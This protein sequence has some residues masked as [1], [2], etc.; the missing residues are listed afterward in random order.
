MTAITTADVVVIGLGAFGSATLYQLAK[1]G[2]KAIGIDRFHPPHTLGS[3]HGES[4]ITR[5]AVGEG[6][7][8]APLV[9]RSHEIWREL[10]REGGGD[11]FSQVGGLILSGRESTTRHH[12]RDDFV[13]SSIAVAERFAIRHEVLN[14][15]EIGHRFPQFGLRGDERGYYEP[16]AGW[17]S[18][19]QTVATQLRLAE[20]R[21]ARLRLGET[22][23][24]CR[25]NG[26]SVRVVTDKGVVEA[27]RC[28]M[29]AGAWMPG[30]VPPLRPLARVQ[31]QALHWYAPANPADYGGDRFPI[32]I[33]IH[34]PSEADSFYGFPASAQDGGVKVATETYARDD[35]PDTV[36]RE[37]AA[38][39]SRS[40]YEAHVKGRL[41]GVTP[42]LLRAASCLYTVMPRAHFFADTLPGEDRILAVS[43]CSGH[44]FKHSAGMGEALAQR[45]LG[46]AGL[47]LSPFGLDSFAS[48]AG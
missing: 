15:A 25:Q 16:E 18:P 17:V 37:V 7:A 33:W 4:R 34:G 20:R 23:L 39:D 29:T 35:D 12:G 36:D 1:R 11:L 43:A 8:Y 2:V 10:E 21:G 46:E 13:S 42:R 19:E 45:V 47:D 48:A 22:V 38:E 5:M 40:M 14:A 9:I 44:G 32:F 30:L 41:L 6:A 28:V 31:R 27:G 3:T 24:E 26:E